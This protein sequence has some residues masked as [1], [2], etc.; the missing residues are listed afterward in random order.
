MSHHHDHEGEAP[1]QQSESRNDTGF[2]DLEIS[3][4][5]FGEAE[6]VTRDAF[7][8]LL[9]EAAKRR[10]QERFGDKIE[11]MARLAVDQLIDEIEANLRIEASIAERARNK[12]SVHDAVRALLSK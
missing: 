7:R 12:V 1:N 5:L 8:E 10:W 3:K 6:S 2:L 9:K 4:V 11:A